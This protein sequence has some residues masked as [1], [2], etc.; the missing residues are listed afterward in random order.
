MCLLIMFMACTPTMEK[1]KSKSLVG[2]VGKLNEA[3][4]ILCLT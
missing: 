4:L 1:K 2:L 3:L